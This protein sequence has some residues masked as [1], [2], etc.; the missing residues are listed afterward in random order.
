MADLTSHPCGGAH[1]KRT[2]VPV[3]PAAPAPVAGSA[4][5]PA[6]VSADKPCETCGKGKDPAT[7]QSVRRAC[8]D[9]GR[10]HIGSCVIVGQY[11]IPVVKVETL[12]RQAEILWSEALHGY[13]EHRWLA[14]G[15]FALACRAY[16]LAGQVE[17]AAA[18]KQ[19]QKSIEVGDR[20][21]V[22][23]SLPDVSLTLSRALMRAELAEAA[24]EVDGFDRHLAGALRVELRRLETDGPVRPVFVPMIAAIT[25]H[26]SRSAAIVHGAGNQPAGPL[27]P[28]PTIP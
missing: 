10:K 22:L 23:P 5:P 3:Q 13:P 21:P 14:V 26:V 15:C 11:S 1:L 24:A 20:F 8:P 16:D 25:R 18:V 9:C 28:Q 27:L 2:T 4:L 19:A 6:A 12:L 7:L 17:A